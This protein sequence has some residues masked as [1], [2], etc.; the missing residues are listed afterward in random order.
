MVI[1]INKVVFAV[2]ACAVALTI[3]GIVVHVRSDRYRITRTFARLSELASVKTGEGMISKGSKSNR[4]GGLFNRESI[5]STP[6]QELS[7]NYSRQEITRTALALKARSQRLSLE[8]YDL[9]IETT[10]SGTAECMVTVR[11]NGALDDGE[12]FDEVRELEC[13]LVEEDGQWLFAQCSVE[14]IVTR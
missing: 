3:V 11:L 10:D 12:V 4:L 9:N 13:R 5:L 7:G 8:F 2:V 1:R 14:K 6:L